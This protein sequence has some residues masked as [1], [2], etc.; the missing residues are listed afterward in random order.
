MIL[1]FHEVLPGCM[2]TRS[3]PSCAIAHLGNFSISQ[4]DLT[5]PAILV[6]L[7]VS[8]SHVLGQKVIL[9]PGCESV[10]GKLRLQ[11]KLTSP[12]HKYHFQ[13]KEIK[14]MIM[15]ITVYLH[16][17]TCDSKLL[18]KYPSLHWT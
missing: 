2:T 18:M 15:I 6:F 14:S 7:T 1:V 17:I 11:Q 5:A 12:N 3:L 13:A 10:A 8:H 4:G 16:S 9:E